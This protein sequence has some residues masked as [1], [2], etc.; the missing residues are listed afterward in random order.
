MNNK[1]LLL[2]QTCVWRNALKVTSSPRKIK[3]TVVNTSKVNSDETNTCGMNKSTHPTMLELILPVFIT[4]NSH[5]VACLPTTVFV[6]ITKS[7][8]LVFIHTV[9]VN[10]I[11]GIILFLPF[12]TIRN[13]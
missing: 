2:L 7:G 9:R 5:T 6:L 3:S 12:T 8:F 10:F 4:S 11:N 1:T 13:N